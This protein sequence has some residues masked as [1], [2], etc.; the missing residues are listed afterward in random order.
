MSAFGKTN[1]LKGCT[2]KLAVSVRVTAENK[3]TSQN[4]EL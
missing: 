4:V 3:T 1:Q 2:V